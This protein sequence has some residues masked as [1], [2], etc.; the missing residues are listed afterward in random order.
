MWDLWRTVALEQVY[1]EYVRFPCHS[2]RWLRHAHN[3]KCRVLRCCAVL[4][5]IFRPLQWTEICHK[6]AE[7]YRSLVRMSYDNPEWKARL[8]PSSSWSSRCC[9][10][11]CLICLTFTIS[12]IFNHLKRPPCIRK[13]FTTLT[14]S[15]METSIQIWLSSQDFSESPSKRARRKFRGNAFPV[16]R[17]APT[18]VNHINLICVSAGF[19]DISWTI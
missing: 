3:L 17:C 16:P 8:E 4:E 13:M 18:A 14:V 5:M 9:F 19:Y 6:L 7:G 1:C 11:W 2:F 12:V 10:H 15:W